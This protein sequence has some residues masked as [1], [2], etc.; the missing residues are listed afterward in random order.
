MRT[1]Y[2]P[3]RLTAAAL[4]GALALSGAAVAALAAP[5]T[6]H[7]A[8]KIS[9]KAKTLTV[10]KSYTLKVKG[11]K[12]KVKWSS[13]NKKVA[14]VSSKG[15]V[16]AKKMG[17]AKIRAKI[18]KKTYTCTVK[19]NPKINAAKKTLGKG[20]SC[21][22]KL[23]GATGTV[24]WYTSNKKVA[25][26]SSKG[27][28][29][30]KK[31]GTATITAKIKNKKVATCKMTV[32]KASEGSESAGSNNTTIS[33]PTPQPPVTPSKPD[34]ASP[35][36]DPTTKKVTLYDQNGK[37]LARYISPT[38]ARDA[39][40]TM[41]EAL[42]VKSSL[43][44]RDDYNWDDL[45][46]ED[47]CPKGLYIDKAC[48]T[49]LNPKTIQAGQSVYLKTGTH[50][51]KTMLKYKDVRVEGAFYNEIHNGELPILARTN[52]N[53]RYEGHLLTYDFDTY[54]WT[55]TGKY[56]ALNGPTGATRTSFLCYFPMKYI[57]CSECGYDQ[58]CLSNIKHF[59]HPLSGIDAPISIYYDPD[60]SDE[61]LLTPNGEPI[62]AY[63]PG[64][65][66]RCEDPNYCYDMREIL[67]LK[68]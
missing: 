42:A 66:L 1:L 16:K 9:T 4:A 8:P 13:T 40:S 32:K 34:A 68:I 63:S 59:L 21:T 5:D 65:I 2:V 51:M 17:T 52:I 35:I 3:D 7:A 19:V 46:G 14:T 6:A 31:A 23:T 25:T 47:K 56:S 62:A 24:K 22:L 67:G 12:K 36:I 58:T 39:I 30:A 61:E 10:G 57:A 33:K 53:N 41:N 38:V 18:G 15:K 29:K 44:T 37:R 20:K 26:V 28:V 49:R 11:T 43:K 64:S 54:A 48:T 27:K 45:I 55:D 50:A 60:I